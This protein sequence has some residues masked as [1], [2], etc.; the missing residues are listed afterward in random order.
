MKWFDKY[1]KL[2]EAVPRGR[3]FTDQKEIL[4]FLSGKMQK[5]D[6]PAVVVEP[7][8]ESEISACLACA[9]EKNLKIVLTS[10]CKPMTARK[11]NGAMLM[12]TSRLSGTPQ[13]SADRLSVRVDAGYPAEALAIDLNR[14]GRR[15]T[16]LLPVPSQMSMGDLMATGWE[17]FR[18]WKTGG[19]L[20]GVRSV[21][22]IS[23]HGKRWVTGSA[24]TGSQA[25]DISSLL[26]NS[27]GA[28][29]VITSV[30]LVLAPIVSEK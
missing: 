22:W 3:I 29:G 16:P 14:I 9:A 27:R 5:E 10:G 4:P 7:A 26:F 21:D 2:R 19:T 11:L 28:L 23:Y 15:W 1:H 12:R 6:L 13:F 18:N 20:S 30:E 17:G 25:P 24:A 8:D